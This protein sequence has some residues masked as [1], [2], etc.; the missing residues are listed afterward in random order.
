MAAI[1]YPPNDSPPTAALDYVATPWVDDNGNSWLYDGTN[2]RWSAY[3]PEPGNTLIYGGVNPTTEGIDGDFYI[4]TAT[5]FI[6]GPKASGSWPSGTSIIGAAG[7]AG[8]DGNTILYGGV[9]PTGEGVNGDFYINTASNFIFGPK[10]GGSWPSG[11]SVIGADG[12]D[13]ADGAAGSAGTDGK[14]I[15]YGGINPTTEG[16]DGDFYINDATNTIFGPKAGGSWPA[17]TSMVAGPY[18]PIKVTFDGQ[19]A[20]LTV[21][22]EVL[23]IVPYTATIDAAYMAATTS[24]SVVVD[25]WAI[26]L[27][28]SPPT[29]ANTITA[30]A[31]LTISSNTYSQDLTLTGWSPSL[32]AVTVMI[33]SVVSCSGINKL[34]IT[35]PVI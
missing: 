8:A 31:P 33:F 22:A 34:Q 27:A 20:D 32:T 6:F 18:G 19:G 29:V 28:S 1:L 15:L 9:D 23:L 17:G 26:T 12:A 25:V 4:N 30:A 10:A 5:D 21:G 13:G 24:G 35:M 2:I 3:A 16:V 11:T 14:T 7:A